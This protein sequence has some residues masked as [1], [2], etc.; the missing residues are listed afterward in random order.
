MN[1]TKWRGIPASGAHCKTS[2]PR[3]RRRCARAL[4]WAAEPGLAA[5]AVAVEL[6]PI[7]REQMQALGYE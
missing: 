2:C 3:L 1:S 4:A 7:Q 5:K 6:T